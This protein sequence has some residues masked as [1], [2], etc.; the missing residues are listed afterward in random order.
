MK[1]ILS[2]IAI[3]IVALVGAVLIVPGLMLG[4]RMPMLNAVG[5]SLLA[6]ALFGATTA[7]NYALSGFVIWSIAGWM[8][9]GG[10]A[11]GAMGI[12]ASRKL[13]ARRALLQRV[14]AV[15]V[16][17]VAAYVAYRSLVGA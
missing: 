2:A 13:A 5:S 10:I 3:L 6:V 17:V 1:K 7:V 15:F 14:F 8:I 4:S 12:W 11:G 16:L 9:V